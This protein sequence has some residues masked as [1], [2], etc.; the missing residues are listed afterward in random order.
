MVVTSKAWTQDKQ[1]ARAEHAAALRKTYGSGQAVVHALAGVTV[2]FDR[3]RF[4]AVMRVRAA[5]KIIALSH[6]GARRISGW[7]R[8]V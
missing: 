2:T 1:A 7:W 5:G 4:T 8:L 6:L 3:G